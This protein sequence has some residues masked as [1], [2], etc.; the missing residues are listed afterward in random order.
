MP[1]RDVYGPA[2]HHLVALVA[3]VFRISPALA[4]HQTI[5]LFYCFGP[6]ALFWMAYRFS[7][8]IACGFWSG[9]LY[10]VIS[11]SAILIPAVRADVGG[12]RNLRRLYNLVVYGESP[13]VA[14]LALVP[15]ALIAIDATIRRGKPVYYALGAIL[16]AALALT[17]VTGT[18]GFALALMAYALAMPQA[19][20]RA[21]LLK[22]ALVALLGYGLAVP[23]LP[24]STIRLI[25]TNSQ[26]S[27]GTNYP[28]R[29]LPFLMAIAVVA[30]LYFVSAR[31]R[32]SPFCRFSLFL[33]AIAGIITTAAFVGSVA[34]VPQ[35]ERFQLEME[36]GCCLVGAGLVH[37]SKGSQF[38]AS[39][40][41]AVLCLAAFVHDRSFAS[42]LI[43]PID[44]KSAIEYRE[45][46]WF[47]RNM[48]GRR[49][50]APG[51]VSFWM[52]I[53]TDTPQFGGCCDQG[54]PNW[55]QRVALYTIY[56]GQNLGPRDGETS[57]LWLQAY[58]VHA[59]G[60]SGAGSRE[61]YKP[62]GNPRKFDGLL[63]VLWREG[64]DIV[65]AVPQ[66]SES[67]AHVIRE[68]QVI[69]REPRDGSDIAP[70]QP[71]V[72]ALNDPNLPLATLRWIG[73]S[74]ATVDAD[75]RDG[76]LVSVQ[77]TYEPGWHA[78]VD[79]TERLI[80][81]DAL[82]MLVVHPQCEARCTIKLFY[83]GGWEMRIATVLG[84]VSL[85]ICLLLLLSPAW[86]RI[87]TAYK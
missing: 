32:L 76:D 33:T 6:V 25:V 22:I 3:V 49:V 59:I 2:L 54:V 39:G 74:S 47:D 60:V 30:V 63:P 43:Q 51:S 5:A 79:G 45:A 37:L 55:Q 81:S 64:G 77:V 15:L 34:I 75:L 70:L 36:M 66:R 73:G 53:F 24:P 83:D 86:T 20:T 71:Y 56:T 27:Q 80:R 67:L 31:L 8:S 29:F 35:P 17:N 65:Y 14:A 41:L 10:S 52:N 68:P 26:H 12:V 19:R 42:R 57:L 23:W 7:G 61:W 58:G 4:F 13:H 46:K 72:A 40:L 18:V 11:P 50:F 44:I 87:R 9:L 69:A 78:L 28:F 21:S 48:S 84:F 16:T 62:F 85:G 1:Y 82:G 38:L